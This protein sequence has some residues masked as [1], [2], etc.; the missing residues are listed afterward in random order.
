MKVKY[1]RKSDVEIKNHI[2]ISS[3]R[4]EILPV[5][6]IFSVILWE[7]M[8]GNG[9]VIDDSPI[10]DCEFMQGNGQPKDDSLTRDLVHTR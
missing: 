8:Q 3:D 1:R 5:C 6:Q 7:F 9:Q 10:R 4:Q 2:T